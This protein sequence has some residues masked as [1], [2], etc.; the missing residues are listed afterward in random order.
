MKTTTMFRTAVMLTWAAM[1]S[2]ATAAPVTFSI[3]DAQG[4][5][6]AEV[7][8]AV[9][10]DGAKGMCGGQFEVHYDPGVLEAKG[11]EP[12]TLLEDSNTMLDCNP[13]EPGRLRVAFVGLDEINGRGEL[14][15]LVF[16]VKGAAGQSSP[17]ELKAVEATQ[18]ENLLEMQA[19]AKHG[20]FTVAEAAL[21][22]PIW[23]WVTLGV[24]AVLVL[25]VL[26]RLGRRKP[27]PAS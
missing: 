10:I 2:A 14:A 21:S 15:R 3:P 19:A 17:L 24:V 23:L 13:D 25:L 5:P 26:M 4:A 20:R 16:A 8:V 9:E 27:L 11:V 18:L 6:G 12:G 1:A 7:R 22:L